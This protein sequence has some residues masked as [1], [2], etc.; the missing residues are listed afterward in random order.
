[1]DTLSE[2]VEF[3]RLTNGSSNERDGLGRGSISSRIS[4]T[5][6]SVD[7]KENGSNRR[8]SQRGKSE[9]KLLQDMTAKQAF[10]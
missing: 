10:E 5:S 3:N 2:E 7:Q 8:S 6:F 4:S 1:M 9:A